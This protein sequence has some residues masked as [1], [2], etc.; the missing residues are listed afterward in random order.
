MTKPKVSVLTPI[1]NTP[2][3]NLKVTIDS[4]LSQTFKDFEYLILN[5]SPDN[6]ELDKFVESYKDPRIRYLK[7]EKNLG[8]E[9]SLNKLIKES[10]GDY[11]AIF[12]HD[13]ISLPKRLEEEV[14]YLDENPKV[15]LVSAQFEVFGVK[16][17]VSQNPINDKDIKKRLEEASCIS[18]TTCMIRKSVL[19]ENNI[20]YE[21]RFFPA[22]SYRL[23]TRLALVT[24]VHN[25]PDILLRYRMDNENT[26]IKH[27]KKRAVA[28]AKIRLEY[29]S[30][31]D[32]EKMKKKFKFD[33]VELLNGFKYSDKRRYYRAQKGDE[34]YFIKTDINS[35]EHEFL[36]AKKMFDMNSEHFVEPIRYINGKTNYY[37]TKW[38]DGKSLDEY[39]KKNKNGLKK[40]GRDFA[41]QLADIYQ[42]LHRSG[43]V[44]RDIIP[45]NFI[46]RDGTL[47]LID[48]YY[49]VEYDNYFEYDYI[50]KDMAKIT[51]LGME[52][53]LGSFKWDDAYS[54]SRI[55][56]YVLGEESAKNDENIKKI[57][58]DI[59]KR[60][61]SA[62]VSEV[63][64]S[65]AENN[66][67]VN[68][69]NKEI[70]EMTNIIKYN[71]SLIETKEREVDA[72]K[73]SKSYKLG[74]M[75][76]KPIRKIRKKN[77]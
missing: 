73:K 16:S 69:K 20:K 68:G 7:N 8:I 24:E 58:N 1:Y 27:A 40:S 39:R 53:A 74:R 45:R 70:I 4:I 72:L 44:H 76:S 21:K 32:I 56:D 64:N 67:I 71:E 28:R 29:S 19:T 34:K 30:A 17:W 41:K 14:K 46:V 23:L 47:V 66:R 3:K 12:D 38:C 2:K 6:I 52:F 5:D 51:T 35:Y 37:V 55:A 63:I 11:I 42:L 48:F 31:V 61:I 36:M 22:A 26:S 77:E 13:D 75:L 9:G 50:K 33:T 57:R 54:F 15:G 60:V 18:H 62:D 65:F 10:R 25:L 49:A 59:G 43:V